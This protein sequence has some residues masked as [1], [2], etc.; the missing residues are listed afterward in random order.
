MSTSSPCGAMRRAP[1][2]P[3]ARW[4][5]SLAARPGELRSYAAMGLDLDP[6]KASLL[7]VELQNDMVHESNLAK[8]GLGSALSESVH[9]RGVLGKVASLLAVARASAVPVFYINVANR[10]G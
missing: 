6:S 8:K 4:V 3:R 1:A 9:R 2:A 7:V 5:R 10:P